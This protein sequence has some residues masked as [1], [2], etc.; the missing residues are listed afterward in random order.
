MFFGESPGS[1]DMI[2]MFVS[3]KQSGDLLRLTPDMFQAFL[4]N[5]RSDTDINQDARL[6]TFN[7]D[8]VTFTTTGEY[9]KLK[10]GP[11]PSI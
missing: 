4:E 1:T 11:P 6:F 3:E 7:I 8:G 5:A 2:G 10:N 9:G